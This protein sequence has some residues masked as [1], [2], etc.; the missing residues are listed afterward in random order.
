MAKSKVKREN[1]E[2]LNGHKGILIW[3]TG[4]PGAGKSTLSRELEYILYKQ[5]VRTYLLDGDN[6]RHGLCK[7]LGFAPEHRKENLRRVGEVAKLFVE[8]GIVTLA[9]FASP[10]LKDRLNIRKLFSPEDFVE[11]YVKCPVEVCRQRDPKGLYAKAKRGEIVGLTGFDAPY[12]PPENPEIVVETDKL[13]VEKCL[14][15]IIEYLNKERIISKK[16]WNLN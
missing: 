8:A 4:L 1:R 12:E 14:E 7:D 2:L 3:F 11:V 5:G 16:S 10:Y 13:N 6:I 9:A 15:K